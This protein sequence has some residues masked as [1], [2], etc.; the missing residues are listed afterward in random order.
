MH[1]LA[2]AE[3]V[4]AIASRHAAGRRVARV[5]L[6]V[7]HLRQ[8]VPAA[9]EFAFELVAQG[10]PLD[11]AELLIEDVAV[12]GRCRGCGAE[13]ELPGFPLACAACGGLD[14]E[15]LRGDELLVEAL[16]LEDDER[17]DAA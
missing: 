16:E 3:S 15:L 11:G 13:S 14:L 12:A 1:E 9:L 4:V 2:L 17:R 8:V 10:T 7:G 5:E 6:R